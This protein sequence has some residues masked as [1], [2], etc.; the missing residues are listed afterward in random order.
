M[1]SLRILET[2]CEELLHAVRE[3]A[4]AGVLG[5][6]VALESMREDF[7]RNG[8]DWRRRKGEWEATLERFLS[9][10][11]CCPLLLPARSVRSYSLCRRRL[12]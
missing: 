2:T 7:L 3:P 11:V 1:M 5:C 10:F 8:E 12:L 4:H 9:A 6:L